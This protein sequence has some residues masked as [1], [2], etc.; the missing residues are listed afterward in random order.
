[1]T[2]SDLRGRASWW[3]LV[4]LAILALVDSIWLYVIQKD[5]HSF[6][7]ICHV[8]PGFDCASALSSRYSR[9][10]DIPLSSY[11][12]ASYLFFAALAL[13][14]LLR[15][16]VRDRNAF[17]LA[18]LL[19]L[20]TA[21][22]ARLAW[23]SYA[24]LSAYCPFCLVLH[25]LTPLMLAAALRALSH[26]RTPLREIFRSEWESIR[27]NRLVQA[28]LIFAIV[29]VAAGLPLY[30]QYARQRMLDA[31]PIYREVLEGRFPR[32]ME[33]KDLVKDRPAIGPDDAR[34]QI[35]EFTDFLCPVCR[36]SR[37]MMDALVKE[38]G[39]RYTFV[40]HPRSS[41]CN[42]AAEHSRP[43]SCLGALAVEYARDSD[44]YWKVHDELFRDDSY[45][46]EENAPRLLKLTGAPS[47]EK[48][49]EDTDVA[50]RLIEDLAIA[51]F[52]GVAHTPSL[53]INGMGVQG[54]PDEWF[55]R[56]VIE[57]EMKRP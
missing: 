47:I 12:V 25:I 38:Y 17:L 46:F 39:I 40:P 55:L 28:G 21:F 5:L 6:A 9:I 26:R 43:G 16:D 14:G 30:E 52:A 35:I 29:F 34:V 51:R 42:P 23:I 8:A 32:L 44:R 37:E 24:R 33:L 13:Q 18:G 27:G 50:M 49:T 22:C 4:A 56:E 53:F 11:A 54:M 48:I 7:A 36:E 31:E 19:T 1:M 45:L 10:F 2:P 41:D 20:A 15:D 3:L 57:R